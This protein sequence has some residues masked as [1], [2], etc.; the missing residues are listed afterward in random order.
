V[1]EGAGFEVDS[2]TIKVGADSPDE[3]RVAVRRAASPVESATIPGDFAGKGGDEPGAAPAY[4]VWQQA[5][6][7]SRGELIRLLTDLAAGL[8]RTSAD[9][10]T[11]DDGR[12]G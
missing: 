7:Q 5:G 9:H 10:R 6:P 8:R 2:T 11:A 4:P 3:G 12:H 1:T